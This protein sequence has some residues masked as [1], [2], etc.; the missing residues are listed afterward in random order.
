VALTW[1]AAT[2]GSTYDVYVRSDPGGFVERTS[3]LSAPNFVDSAVSANAAYLYKI[4]VHFPGGTTAWS[5][6]DLTTTITFD[7]T[8]AV[9]SPIRLAHIDQ[10]TSV[11]NLV[12]AAAGLG[13][14]AWTDAPQLG[15]TVRASQIAEL[16]TG[17]TDARTALALGPVT[18]ARPTL[19]GLP[20]RASDFTEIRDALK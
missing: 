9:G 13:A 3:G 16:R 19:S 1:T 17:I 18:F 8:L 12:R 7:P 11:T 15:G 20:I 10:L 2:V 14:I 6:V 4:L 5:N